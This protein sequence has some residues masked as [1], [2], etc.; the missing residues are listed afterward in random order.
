ME[1]KLIDEIR[2]RDL[3]LNKQYSYVN[4]C[5]IEDVIELF[6]MLMQLYKYMSNNSTTSI[7]VDEV[8]DYFNIKSGPIILI[9]SDNC[10]YDLRKAYLF[11]LQINIDGLNRALKDG[12][13]FIYELNNCRIN[14]GL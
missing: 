8:L 7:T 14:G 5:K 12:L 1:E 2:N 3:F 11:G 13:I 4:G 10:W 9:R 6:K